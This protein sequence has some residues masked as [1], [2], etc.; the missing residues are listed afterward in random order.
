MGKE[1][2]HGTDLLIDHS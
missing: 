2:K 1:G